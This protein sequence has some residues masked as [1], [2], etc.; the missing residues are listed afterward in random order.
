MQLDSKQSEYK[1]SFADTCL[2][3]SERATPGPWEKNRWNDDCLIQEVNDST[4]WIKDYPDAYICKIGG[5]GYTMNGNAEFI[6]AGRQM[7][8]ELATRLNKACEALR[9]ASTFVINEYFKQNLNELAK[10]L[11]ALPEDDK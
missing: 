4:G 10:E 11:E 8:P 2:E 5:W 1:K 3:L 6:A 9:A 7:L